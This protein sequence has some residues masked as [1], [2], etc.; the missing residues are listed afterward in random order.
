MIDIHV[1]I[2]PFMDDG[3]ADMEN[4]L[5]MAGIAW[6]DGISALVATPHV[7]AGAYDNSKADILLQVDKVNTMLKESGNPVKVLPGAEYYLEPDLPG[8]LARGEALTLND[9]GRYLLVELPSALV[10]DYT[11]QVLYE[12]QLQG[13]IPI[14][15]HPERNA[16]FMRNP[17]LL[18]SFVDKGVLAQ[19]TSI[20]VTGLFGRTVRQAALDFIENG[21]AH[22]IASDA[23]SVNGRAP[24]LYRAAAEIERLYGLDLA[25]AL[26]MNNPRRIVDGLPLEAMPAVKKRG[27]WKRWFG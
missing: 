10:P 7:M 25:Q 2:L 8:Q 9:S 23:H 11:G 14:I 18:K 15:A 17:Q 26:V 4:S 3:S 22:A 1:H 21:L 24:V 13:V 5:A 6:D 27:L 19:V 20:S 12:I 16:G